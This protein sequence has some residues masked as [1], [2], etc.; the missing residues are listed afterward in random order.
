[1]IDPFNYIN[2]IKAAA[3]FSVQYGFERL[4]VTIG[5]DAVNELLQRCDASADLLQLVR[6]QFHVHFLLFDYFAHGVKFLSDDFVSF[7]SAAGI[8]APISAKGSTSGFASTRTRMRSRAA[9][10]D[11]ASFSGAF[12]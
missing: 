12:V 5:V 2:G 11:A 3:G 6:I 9:Q 10:T 8:S 4:S 1:M 7:N